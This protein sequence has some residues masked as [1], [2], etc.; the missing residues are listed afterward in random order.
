MRFVVDRHLGHLARWLRTLGYDAFFQV[1]AS[2]EL[3]RSELSKN[4]TVFVSTQTTSAHALGAQQIVHVP[5]DDEAA[6]LRIV[7]SK[8]P[9]PPTALM[10]T[11]CVI[12][13][14]P[15]VPIAKEAVRG[16]VPDAV[17]ATNDHYTRC[18]ACERIYWEGTH[19]ARLRSRLVALLGIAGDCG[20]S[21]KT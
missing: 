8:L 3:L 7:C 1:D 2:E 5:K 21:G 13:N 20:P 11:R 17:Y 9:E 18:P 16:S 19:T 4:V 12:C 15:V 14:V 6:Q 10:F